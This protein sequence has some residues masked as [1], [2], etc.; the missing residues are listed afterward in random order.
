MYC[1]IKFAS[2][3]SLYDGDPIDVDIY[4]MFVICYSPVYCKSNQ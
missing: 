1:E 2:V 4:T 3:C